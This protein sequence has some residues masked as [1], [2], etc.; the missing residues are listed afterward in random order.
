MIKFSINKNKL[1]PNIFRYMEIIIVSAIVFFGIKIILLNL[2][3]QLNNLNE[4]W[5]FVIL[6]GVI[7]Y[8]DDIIELKL[9]GHSIFNGGK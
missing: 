1:V 4:Y 9:A 7:N 5:L 2:F 8:I 3:P 6:V